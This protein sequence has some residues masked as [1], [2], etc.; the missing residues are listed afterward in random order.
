MCYHITALLCAS[1]LVNSNFYKFLYFVNVKL[2][3]YDTFKLRKG[4][5]TLFLYLAVCL[6]SVITT[7]QAF[8]NTVPWEYNSYCTVAHNRYLHTL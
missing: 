5:Y 2:F 4:G 6:R 3:T 8:I 1:K 7:T